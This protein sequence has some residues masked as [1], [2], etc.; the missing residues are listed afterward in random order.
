MTKPHTTLS[1]AVRALELP[2]HSARVESQNETGS[3]ATV[4]MNMTHGLLRDTK[5]YTEDQVRAVLS[6][7]AELVEQHEAQEPVAYLRFRAAQQ[8]SGIGGHDIEHAEWFETCHA[9]EIG[10]DKL[11]AFPVYAQPTL[12]ATQAGDA[13]QVA[14]LEQ[15]REELGQ[16]IRDLITALC[17]WMPKVNGTEGEIAERVF[18]DCFLLSGIDGNLPDNFKTAQELGWVTLSNDI[19]QIT[20]DFIDAHLNVILIASGSALRN[21]T[22]HKTREG[23]RTALRAAIRAAMAPTTTRSE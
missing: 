8:W 11:P 4:W 14:Q 1:E 3:M 16:E 5:I 22:M 9:H 19:S 12:A 21:Y 13:S 20:D 10:D 15:Q 18:N 7:A 23:M 2:E 17:F 6:A